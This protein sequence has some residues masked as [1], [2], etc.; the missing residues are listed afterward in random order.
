MSKIIKSDLPKEKLKGI[1]KNLIIN[2]DYTIDDAYEVSIKYVVSIN[3]L[4]RKVRRL[5][6]QLSEFQIVW[7]LKES[8]KLISALNDLRDAIGKIVNKR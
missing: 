7:E 3:D 4:E 8:K 6:E 5:I 1:V 2:P